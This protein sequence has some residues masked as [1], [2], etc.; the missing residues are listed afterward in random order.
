MSSCSSSYTSLWHFA[1][2]WPG[3]LQRRGS[4]FDLITPAAVSISWSSRRNCSVNS[5]MKREQLERPLRGNNSVHHRVLKNDL[6]LKVWKETIGG[7]FIMYVL[8]L[9]N[10]RIWHIGAVIV[11]LYMANLTKKDHSYQPGRADQVFQISIGFISDV[12]LGKSRTAMFDKDGAFRKVTER[13]LWLEQVGNSARLPIYALGGIETYSAKVLPNSVRSR[14]I[15]IKLPL[16]GHP[17]CNRHSA[18]TQQLHLQTLNN[19]AAVLS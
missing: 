9:N 2:C 11:L 13:P 14:V 12:Q 5:G 10:T 16:L 17:R 6:I 1:A 7:N 15:L 18:I 19:P 4:R 3:E 8:D